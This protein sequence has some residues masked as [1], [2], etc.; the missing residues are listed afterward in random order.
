M[1][2]LKKSIVRHIKYTPSK[3]HSN[4]HDNIPPS[5]G[6]Y[7]R[8]WRERKNTTRTLVSRRMGHAWGAPPPERCFGYQRT[9]P[10]ART[11]STGIKGNRTLISSSVLLSTTLLL[12]TPS[13]IFVTAE[14]IS[15]VTCSGDGNGIGTSFGE[16]LSKLNAL[17]L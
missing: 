2:Y 17:R 1:R 6:C 10:G 12:H 14:P 7:L 8:W 4:P 15:M 16:S 9:S 11:N 13:L 3:S 5:C